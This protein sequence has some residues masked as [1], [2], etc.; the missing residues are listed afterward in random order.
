LTLSDPD[1]AAVVL[2]ANLAPSVHNTQPTRWRRVSGSEVQ[3]RDARERHLPVGDPA[4]RDAGVSHGAAIEGF[5]LACSAREWAAGVAPS[6]E[7]ADG[8]GDGDVA[9]LTL[10]KGA[11]PDPLQAWVHVRRTYR[12]RFLP[13]APNALDRLAEEPDIVIVRARDGIAHVAA[14]YDTASLATFRD[15]AFRAELLSWMRLSRRD[16]RWTRDGLNAQA[17][18]MSGVE[19]AG[20]GLVLRPGVFEALD[21]LGVAAGFVAEARTVMSAAG[22][23]LFHRPADE[24]PLETGRRYYRL[25]LSITRSGLSAAPMAVLADDPKAASEMARSF[26]LPPGRRLIT[27]L[28]VG[29][30]PERTMPP[31]PRLPIEDLLS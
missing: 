24:H 25:W 5:V 27:A 16:P 6:V 11:A 21:R 28:R 4:G 12:G 13:A 9:T 30:A 1:F 23:L 7:P 14:V 2:E 20:A 26:S 15:A 19:A 10:S 29:R 31:K 8:D 3:V 17:M 18:E 22:I